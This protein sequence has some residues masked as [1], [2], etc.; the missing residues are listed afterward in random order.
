MDSATPGGW[1]KSTSTP[2]LGACSWNPPPAGQCL[3]FNGKAKHLG[4]EKYFKKFHS[5]VLNE[6]YQKKYSVRDTAHL[7]YGLSFFDE[8]EKERMPKTYWDVDWKTVKKTIQGWVR[9]IV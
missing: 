3:A 6:L 7:L 8:A 1:I 9:E 2:F 4:E 5:K